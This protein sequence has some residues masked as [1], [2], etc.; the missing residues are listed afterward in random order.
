MGERTKT[1]K[2]HSTLQCREQETKALVKAPRG[3]RLSL[4]RLVSLHGQSEQ[5]SPLRYPSTEAGSG[6]RHLERFSKSYRIWGCEGKPVREW[7]IWP[8][9]FLML[10]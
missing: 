7:V 3:S 6:G 5:I 1:G 10:P 9:V 4:Q 8:L 2:D